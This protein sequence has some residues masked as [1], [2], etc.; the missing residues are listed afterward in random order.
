MEEAHQQMLQKKMEHEVESLKLPQDTSVTLERHRRSVLY[1]QKLQANMQT[2]TKVI[3]NARQFE[4]QSREQLVEATRNE[5]IY[6]R[7][8]E[9]QLEAYLKELDQLQQKETDE[10][11]ANISRRGEDSSK[12]NPH[13][14]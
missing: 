5:K 11:A 13:Q 12:K 14:D 4:E 1:Q 6:Q 3:A 2:Q 9:K 8:K 7:L 10:I